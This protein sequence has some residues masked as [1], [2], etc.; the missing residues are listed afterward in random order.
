M[1]FQQLV[2]S[3]ERGNAKN[4]QPESLKCVQAGKNITT[5]SLVMPAIVLVQQ[6]L[7]HSPLIS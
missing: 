2:E 3:I 6:T 1:E 7:G 4:E 5:K